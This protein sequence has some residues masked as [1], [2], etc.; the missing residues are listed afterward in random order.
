LEG[1]SNYKLMKR[2]FIGIPIRS[3]QVVHT[4]EIWKK[5]QNLNQNLLKWVNS[6][7]WHITLVFLGSTDESVLPEIQELI[8]ESF[9]SI[10][11]F[12][13]RLTVPGVFPNFNNPK[14]LWLGIESIQALISA[15]I[16]LVEKLQQNGFVLESKP[17]K[18]HLTLARIKNASHRTSLN[19]LI[20]RY[21]DT[22]F[23]PVSIDRV[24]LYES[25]STPDGPVYL[26][27]FVKELELI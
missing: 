13:T 4:T 22:D 5:D 11:A 16:R 25:K 2:L 15:Q 3:V 10:A 6:E 18:P 14:V 1:A 8:E 21:Q 12:S 19:S 7:N 20:E 24:I 17:L 23:G 26:P 27:L 9:A